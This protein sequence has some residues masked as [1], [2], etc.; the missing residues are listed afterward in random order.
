MTDKRTYFNRW[1]RDVLSKLTANPDAGLVVLITSLTL[2]ERYLREKSNNDERTQLD[3][4][5]F[6]EF[7]TLFPQIPDVPV[8]KKFWKVARHGLMHQAT[9]KTRLDA[10]QTISE[11]GVDDAVDVI[12]YEDHGNEHCFMVSPTKFAKVTI[13]TI[14][15]DFSTFEGNRSPNHPLP[16][17]IDRSGTDPTGYSGYRKAV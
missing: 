16:E 15:N 11:I 9:F 1:F 10:T 8:A 7:I 13:A 5:F 2:L 17:K 4:Q 12:R 6:A 14:E 3:D